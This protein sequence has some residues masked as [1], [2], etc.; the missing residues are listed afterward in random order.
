SITLTPTNSIVAKAPTNSIPD[1]NTIAGATE[2][3]GGETPI[4]SVSA[5]KEA[6]KS[7]HEFVQ[8]TQS[9]TL[10]VVGMLLLVF[11]AISMF[12][13]IEST[14]NDIWGV[15]RGRN[16]LVRILLYWTIPTLGTLLVTAALLLASGPHFQT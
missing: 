16:W 8:N 9:G 3:P 1:T 2:N 5:Q 6:A 11:V 13:R 12:S 4:V 7:I 15:T 10:G 14:F